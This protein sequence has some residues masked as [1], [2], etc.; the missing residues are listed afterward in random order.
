MHK[1]GGRVDFEAA[2]MQWL[3]R[4]RRNQPYSSSAIRFSAISILARSAGSAPRFCLGPFPAAASVHP[5][6]AARRLLVE[7]DRP[8][9]AG[10]LLVAGLQFGACCSPARQTFFR[11]VDRASEKFPPRLVR[12]RC[13][14][15]QCRFQFIASV[16]NVT[17][18]RGAILE[19]GE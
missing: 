1:W 14:Q 2:H 7:L 15:V 12:A 10:A 19:N 17:D 11:L 13:Q 3:R 4:I 9:P 5:R 18:S 6:T 16:P 8:P